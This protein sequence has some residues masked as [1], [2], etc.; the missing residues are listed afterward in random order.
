M[1]SSKVNELA[2]RTIDFAMLMGVF[3]EKTCTAGARASEKSRTVGHSF[4]TDSTNHD[5]KR[6]KKSN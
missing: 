2:C 6:A 4:N 3:L 1:H 5:S